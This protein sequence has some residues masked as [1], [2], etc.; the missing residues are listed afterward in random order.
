MH[1]ED[2]KKYEK[3]VLKMAKLEEKRQAHLKEI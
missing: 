1:D 3:L 2:D